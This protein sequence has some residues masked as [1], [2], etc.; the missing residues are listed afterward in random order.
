MNC[1]QTIIEQ[2]NAHLRDCVYIL[3]T[4]YILYNYFRLHY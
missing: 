3:A 2:H 4:V 1:F